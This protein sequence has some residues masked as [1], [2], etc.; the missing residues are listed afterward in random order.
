MTVWGVAKGPGSYRR[1]GHRPARWRAIRINIEQIQRYK[2]R[3]GGVIPRAAAKAYLGPDI[4]VEFG[5]HRGLEREFR[6]LWQRRCDRA[7]GRHEGNYVG[8]GIFSN[9]SPAWEHSKESE[10]EQRINRKLKSAD[11]GLLQT[12]M[13]PNFTKMQ[14]S[15]LSAFEPHF[16]NLLTALPPVSLHSGLIEVDLQPL[17]FR[18]TLDSAS[19]VLL[20]HAMSFRSQLDPPGS[21]SLRFLDAF[22]YAQMKVHRR[23]LLDWGRMKPF[24]LVY[25]LLKGKKKGKKKGKQ[26]EKFE[27]ACETVHSILDGMIAELLRSFHQK[28]C[29]KEDENEDEDRNK[30]Y[31]FLDE[32]AKTALDQFE[33]CY[34]ILN[35]LIAGR[36]TT[37]LL[38]SNAFFVLARR[39]NIWACVR[40]EVD[41]TF[42]GR[43]PDYTTLRNMKQVRNLLNECECSPF[44]LSCSSLHVNSIHRSSSLTPSPL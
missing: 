8:P 7:V 24:G 28:P 39:P 6:V 43:L 41:E 12:L 33:L 21:A 13:R 22:D 16:Q 34:G 20:G 36:D 4:F 38:L 31:I 19:E 37:G 27:G 3:Y 40:A 23:S 42:K 25:F 11:N 18:M 44:L 1:D 14:I 10:E 9:D 5:G 2:P 26:K 15:G 29:S 35:V 32:M 30:K 17:F